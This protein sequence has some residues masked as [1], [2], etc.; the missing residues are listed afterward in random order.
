MS[1]PSAAWRVRSQRSVEPMATCPGMPAAQ[2]TP[3]MLLSNPLGV[4]TSHTMSGEPCANADVIPH[5]LVRISAARNEIVLFFI[6]C[7]LLEIRL[8]ELYCAQSL[9]KII[10]ES[11][12]KIVT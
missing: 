12:N 3:T 9:A 7:L 11:R 1:A 8:R 2:P 5:R 10:G 6:D 4:G